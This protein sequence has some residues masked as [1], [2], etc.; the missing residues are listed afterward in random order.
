MIYRGGVSATIPT[1][2][3]LTPEDKVAMAEFWKFYEPIA[4]D[5]SA[6][7]RRSL[8]G[9]PEWVPLLRSI[10]EAQAAEQDRRS[11]ALQRE[12]IVDGN[13]AP[14]L[15]D[16]RTQ[17]ATY[18]RMGVSWLAWY[19]VIAI[20]REAIRRR[21]VAAARPQTR[22]VFS[23]GEGMTRLLDIAMA[24]IGEAYLAT[25]EAIIAEQ[26]QAIRELST[27]V[28]QVTGHVLVVPL[29]GRIDNARARQ[30]TETLLVAIRD[31][32]ARGVVLD[33]T[34]VPQVDVSVAN[35]LAMTCDAARL[36][37]ASIVIT[38]MSSEIARAMVSL[39]ARLPAAD[40]HIDLLD[41]ITALEHTLTDT[42]A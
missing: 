37:G 14:Y 35:H 31:R 15:E 22:E 21:L 23:I 41:G 17:G 9:L 13:W 27:P 5:V 20:Y 32:R 10:P 19:D 39:G 2:L 24:H 28:L 7:L 36:M 11:Q 4:S 6:D 16:L 40:T 1:R 30:L 3:Q 8:E 26:Q 29:V 18:A 38:G 33:V 42:P 12:A 25:K 34:G